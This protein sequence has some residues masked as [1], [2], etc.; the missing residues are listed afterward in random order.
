MTALWLMYFIPGRELAMHDGIKALHRTG[1][2]FDQI[3]WNVSRVRHHAPLYAILLSNRNAWRTILH[4]FLQRR[5]RLFS[6]PKNT[7]LSRPVQKLCHRI[8]FIVMGGFWHQTAL[9]DDGVGPFRI[10]RPHGSIGE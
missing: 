7:I 9:C 6:A 2:A 3:I 5:F 10:R 4:L 8:I 1:G